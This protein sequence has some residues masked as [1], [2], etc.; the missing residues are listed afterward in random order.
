MCN[1]VIVSYYAI[2]T[3]LLPYNC[4]YSMLN[5]SWDLNVTDSGNLSDENF[6]SLLLMII[7]Y[8]LFNCHVVGDPQSIKHK[9]SH[10]HY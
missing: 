5:S 8:L 7:H 6:F 3:L 1:I 10:T 4:F 2:V 9:H